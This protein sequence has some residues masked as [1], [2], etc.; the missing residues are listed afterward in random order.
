[1]AYVKFVGRAHAA[2]ESPLL[3]CDEPAGITDLRL[4]ARSEPGET[5]F[6]RS[7]AEAEM[8]HQRERFLMRDENVD[9]PALQ[10]V[11]GADRRAELLSSLGVFQR[12]GVQFGHR[13]DRLRT[14]RADGAVT[15]GFPCGPPPP[16]RSQQVVGWDLHVHQCDLGCAT[17]VDR[18]E[19][20]QVKIGRMAIDHKEANAAAI[21]WLARCTCR[22]DQ[23]V[24]P[25]R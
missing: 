17:A 10:Y 4:G 13:A 12:R 9:H 19:A 3:V 18:L 20:L 7:E 25:R 11:E 22:D 1:M 24:G 15:A 2:V 23:L 5:G 8:L 16:L 14:E 21:V 6:I